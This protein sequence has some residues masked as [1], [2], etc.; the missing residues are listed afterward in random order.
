MCQGSAPEYFSYKESPPDLPSGHLNSR[1]LIQSDQQDPHSLKY[2]YSIPKSAPCPVIDAHVHVF[3]QKLMDA[4]CYAHKNGIAR[5]LNKFLAKTVN[6]LNKR[7]SLMENASSNSKRRVASGLATVMPG[8]P[9]AKDILAE[10]FSTLG[11]AGIKM[12]SHV[13]CIPANHPTMDEVYE[14]CIQ[15]D[16]PVLIHAGKDPNSPAYKVDAGKICDASIVED[17]LQRYPN[18]RICIPHLGMNQ[19]QEF[20][21][22]MEK[23]PNLYLDTTMTMAAFFKSFDDDK[24]L[25]EMLREMII[26]YND[27]ILY[28]S[29]WPNIPYDWCREL[30]NL[31][32]LIDGDGE[33][34]SVK[35]NPRQKGLNRKTQ[36]DIVLENIL[37]RN[38]S[39]FYRITEAELGNGRQ[40]GSNL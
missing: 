1:F 32:S 25:A 15:F 30:A 31:V 37:W 35:N 8:E 19:Y 10:A 7:D 2:E 26:K 16:K 23:Y 18:L 9:G 34:T 36:G 4:V 5:D 28:G 21:D 14:T 22:L 11:L 27:R 33:G 39:K 12:H 24:E 29:D 3:P 13:Q 17:V 20:F 40:N 6:D 38:A